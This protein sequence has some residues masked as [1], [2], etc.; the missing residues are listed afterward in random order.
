[1]A[2][3]SKFTKHEGWM[4]SC[5]YGGPT[6]S[7][8]DATAAPPVHK[9][10][11]PVAVAPPTPAPSTP[12]AVAPATPRVGATGHASAGSLPTGFNCIGTF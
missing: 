12:V 10:A 3:K 1:M 7:S 4:Y 6:A 8:A 5:T 11:T 2:V 9:N